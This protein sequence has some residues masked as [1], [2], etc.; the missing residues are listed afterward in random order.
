MT[1]AGETPARGRFPVQVGNAVRRLRTPAGRQVLWSVAA[2]GW[3]T[4]HHGHVRL[5]YQEYR[6]GLRR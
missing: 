6:D 1:G 5:C 4:V 2:N 3:W